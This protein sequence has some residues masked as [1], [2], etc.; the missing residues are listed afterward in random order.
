MPP[1]TNS[2]VL[3]SPKQE[4]WKNYGVKIVIQGNHDP[5]IILILF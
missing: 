3:E 2:K 4:N 5:E 1:N